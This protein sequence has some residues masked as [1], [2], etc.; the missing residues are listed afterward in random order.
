[1]SCSDHCIRQLGFTKNKKDNMKIEKIND[2]QLRCVL[3]KED[4]ENRKIRLSELVCGGEKARSLLRDMIVRASREL[5]FSFNNNPLM[6]EA[7]PTGKDQLVLIITRVDD[8]GE[9]DS[10]FKHLSGVTDSGKN[11]LAKQDSADM[12]TMPLTGA[13]D[14]LN[15]LKELSMQL[16][17][18]DDGMSGSGAE[19]G[20]Q[21]SKR[22]KA[23]DGS[24]AENRTEAGKQVTKRS[25]EQDGALTKSGSEAE[26]TISKW[27]KE[28][29]AAGLAEAFLKRS[30]QTKD[31]KS[32][33]K[34]SA[35]EKNEKTLQEE[36][37]Q[38]TRFY[39]F[40]NLENVLNAS[41]CV[42]ETYKGENALYKNP[43]D[44]CFYLLVKKTDTE[45]EQFNRICNVLSEYSM[46]MDYFTGMDEFFREHMQ[47]IVAGHAIQHLRKV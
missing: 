28:L 25:K 6:I 23:K 9:L 31:K 13:D 30:T 38:F 24:P 35:K 1:M 47:V 32:R 12:P 39:L 41:K 3:T 8:P 42:P 14:V 18:Q 27:L 17:E 44:G 22:L 21:A 15:L 29:G 46:P 7:V 16:D 34:D 45:P 26:K 40:R 36:L 19:T 4:L 43:E 2:R 20:E 11:D 37:C 33:K 10:R 5:G